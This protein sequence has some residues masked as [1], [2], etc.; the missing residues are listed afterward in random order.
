MSRGARELALLRL[1]AQGLAGPRL[2]TPFA[3]AERLLCLQAQDYWSGLASVAVRA[4]VGLGAVEAEFD[5]GNIVRA[6]PLRGTLHLLAARDLTW[7]REL[8]APRQLAAAALREQRLGLDPKLISRATDVVIETLTAGGPSSRAELNHAW[9]AAAIDSS[10][11]RSYHLIWHLAHTGTI[12][13]GPTRGGQQ[14]FALSGTWLPPSA[15]GEPARADALARLARRYF[16]GHG[17]ATA[18]DLAR[19]ANITLADTRQAITSARAQLQT[20]AVDGTEYLLAPDT[21]D[22]LAGCRRQAGE[23]LALPHFDEL[24]LGYRD[25]APTLP[26]ERDLDVFANRNGVP[27]P[28][29]IHKGQVVATWKRPGKGAGTEVSVRPLVP[30]SGAVLRR[31]EA[32]AAAI[33]GRNSV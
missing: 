25:R 3:V 21:E 16:S 4:G 19:W 10:G 9:A 14:L 2:D 18:A 15:R 28:T 7:L 1:V 13:L 27:A 24:L 29:I 22:T 30:L 5:A 32:L 17:P 31:A 12:V 33:S 26:P 6:W 11:Q 23:V 20:I 8:L